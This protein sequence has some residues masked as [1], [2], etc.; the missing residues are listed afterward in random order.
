MT[1]DRLI[2]RNA[3]LKD[4][5]RNAYSVDDYQVFGGPTWLSSARFDVEAKAV[6]S[7]NSEQLLLMLQT[8]LKERFRLAAHR[9]TK[10]LT[11]YALVLD[12]NGPK[13][14]ALNATEQTCYPSCADHASPLDRMRQRDLPSLARYL[15]RLGADRPVVD[16]TGLT[17][18]FR[19]ELDMQRIMAAAAQISAPPTN[20]SVFQ[21]SV[22]A[23]QDQLGLKLTSTKA[24]V[25]VL[26][27]D[28]A[29]KPTPD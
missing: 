8:S 22:D 16:R 5:I 7:T 9:E 20:E 25:D 1:P 23:V 17:G 12:K 11:V 28:G 19:I 18:T 4:L 3:T 21:A 6:A 10:E 27:I 26:V 24:H 2:A 14:H 15:T 29:Q 13:F